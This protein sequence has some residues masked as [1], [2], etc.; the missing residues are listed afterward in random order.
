MQLLAPKQVQL[1]I[2]SSF[3]AGCM[4][5]I[6]ARS[7]EFAPSPLIKARLSV[8]HKE[9]EIPSP[10]VGEGRGLRCTHSSVPVDSMRCMRSEDDPE[11]AREPMDRT[12]WWELSFSIRGFENVTVETLK[13]FWT[14]SLG[15]E[16][17][18]KHR[19]RV[20]SLQFSFCDC[21][22]AEHS[23]RLPSLPGALANEIL[24]NLYV[25]EGQSFHRRQPHTDV[26]EE[27]FRL[28][29]QGPSPFVLV[30]LL[31]WWLPST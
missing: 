26:R 9:A 3:F 8:F 16:N 24:L 29:L 19:N 18:K 17:P 31:R 15:S 21:G 10:K 27:D 23:S 20:M 4:I 14:V 22:A 5:R 2:G 1:R 28:V 25:G 30:S 6:R 12:R 13:L 11:D 7:K